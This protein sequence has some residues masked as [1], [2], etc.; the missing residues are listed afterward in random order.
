MSERPRGIGWKVA[1]NLIRWI[2][3]L[4][5]KA[6]MLADDISPTGRFIF[7]SAMNVPPHPGVAHLWKVRFQYWRWRMSAKIADAFDLGWSH[8]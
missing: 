5:Y 3:D 7:A 2:P 8:Q 4:Q 6:R 1:R